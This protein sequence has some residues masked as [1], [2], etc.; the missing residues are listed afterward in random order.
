[1][2]KVSKDERRRREAQQRDRLLHACSIWYCLYHE[3]LYGVNGGGEHD[4]ECVPALVVPKAQAA[5]V[6]KQ[7]PKIGD[8]LKA[9]FGLLGFVGTVTMSSAQ[10]RSANAKQDFI[11]KEMARLAPDASRE[12]KLMLR[13]FVMHYAIRDIMLDTHDSRRE[14]RY[15]LQTTG[16]LV[17]H[18]FPD[19]HRFDDAGDQLYPPHHS[20]DVRR[21]VRICHDEA[22]Y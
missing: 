11:E 17:E 22:R 12:E 14:L 10:A 9:A 4:G 5:F 7:M 13:T 21:L 15:L 3:W 6:R 18:V 2:A 19:G 20:R 16:T 1:M 8:W